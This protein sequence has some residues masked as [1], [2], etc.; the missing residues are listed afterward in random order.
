MFET[1]RNVFC[2]GRNYK[3][4]AEELGNELPKEPMLFTKPTHALAAMDGSEVE[5]PGNRGEVHYEAELVLHIGSAYKPGMRADEL[6]DRMA[7]GIDLTLRDVQSVIKSKGLPW[8]PAKG[9]LGAAPL[10][11]WME[12]P[13]T[14]ALAVKDFTLMKN[15]HEVQRGNVSRMIFDVQTIVDYCAAN[16]GLGAGDVIFTGTPE[17]VGPV[18]DG[19]LFELQWGGAPAGSCLIR[20]R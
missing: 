9:F 11:A 12:F 4:H 10:G 13:G 6:I 20:L 19:D 18:G 8:L 2:V 14:D 5:I 1:I 15:G 7:F 17:G 3:A 16:Y